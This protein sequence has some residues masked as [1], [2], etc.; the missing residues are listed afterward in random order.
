MENH[1]PILQQLVKY[2]MNSQKK[3]LRDMIEKERIF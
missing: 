2:K 3:Y 1:L